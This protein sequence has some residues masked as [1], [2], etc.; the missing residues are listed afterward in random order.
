MEIKIGKEKGIPFNKWK[1]EEIVK[2]HKSLLK[3]VYDGMISDLKSN[4]KTKKYAQDVKR[5][6]LR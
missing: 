4:K 6:G 3:E 2:K 5:V 1:D